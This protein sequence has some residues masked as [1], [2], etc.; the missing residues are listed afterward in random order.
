ML[1][2]VVNR[3]K[4]EIDTERRNRYLFVFF[5]FFVVVLI[6]IIYIKREAMEEKLLEL[7]EETCGKLNVATL[8]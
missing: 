4:N 1:K 8:V 3:V 6:K 2:E 7:L 5:V